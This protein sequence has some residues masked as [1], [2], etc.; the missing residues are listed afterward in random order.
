MFR[1]TVVLVLLSCSVAFA[2][3]HTVSLGTPMKVKLFVGPEEKQPMEIT[4]RTLIVDGKIREFVTG[5]T[6]DVTDHVFVARTAFRMNDSLP[7]DGRTQPKWRWQR[8]GWVSVDRESGRVATLNLPDFDPYYSV[9][10]WYRDYVAYC[11]ISSD[12]EKVY[13]I[14][15]EIGDRKPIVK[16]LLGNSTN[17]EVPDSECGAPVW[18]RQ[19]MRVTFSPKDKPVV[20]YEVHGHASQPQIPDD[21]NDAGDSSKPT[22]TPE[23]H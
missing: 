15:A 10:S 2:R 22:S 20:T 7:D 23:A 19:P 16:K 12:A 21:N 14:V 18:A 11:G 13:A 17:A 3:N 5:D 6:H 4:V 1:R 8:G 9:A